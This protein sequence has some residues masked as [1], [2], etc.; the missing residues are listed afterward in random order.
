MRL[1]VAPG[2]ELDSP[3]RNGGEGSISQGAENTAKVKW[4]QRN[5][6]KYTE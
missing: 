2:A 5:K 3:G 6:Y 1:R 4:A